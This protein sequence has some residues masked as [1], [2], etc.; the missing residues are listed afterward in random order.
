MTEEEL[1][2]GEAEF[3]WENC[4]HDGEGKLGCEVC[5][6]NPKRII[7]RYKWLYGREAEVLKRTITDRAK[8][9]GASRDLHLTIKEL[10]RKL[11]RAVEHG[12][13]EES[14]KW[15]AIQKFD[16]AE[17]VIYAAMALRNSGYDGPFIGEVCEPLFS[18]LA[19]YEKH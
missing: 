9:I 15:K 17:R 19:E 11:D 3:G 10:H 8:L 18:A 4:S 7:A 6:S 16:A 12:T 5:D 13:D 14:Q 2:A 1:L